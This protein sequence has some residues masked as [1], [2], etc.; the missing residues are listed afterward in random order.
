[1][2]E[3][4]Y[5]TNMHLTAF[6]FREQIKRSLYAVAGALVGAAVVVAA[7]SQNAT[8]AVSGR[9]VSPQNMRA[10]EPMMF[11]SGDPNKY[12]ARVNFKGKQTASLLKTGKAA[13]KIKTKAAISTKRGGLQ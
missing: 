11:F 3:L 13:A 5:S 1:M 2:H 9:S 10:A 8:L 12:D 4:L 6:G 7:R